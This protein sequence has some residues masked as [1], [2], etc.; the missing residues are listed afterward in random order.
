MQEIVKLMVDLRKT[1]LTQQLHPLIPGPL[2]DEDLAPI[3]MPQNR[4]IEHWQLPH[5]HIGKSF[6]L[7]ALLR[8]L[9][10]R[11]RVPLRAGTWVAG[12]RVRVLFRSGVRLVAH[13]VRVLLRS[14]VRVPARRV[15]APL[16]GGARLVPVIHPRCHFGSGATVFHATDRGAAE[17][18][19][20]RA[21]SQPRQEQGLG[22]ARVPPVHGEERGHQ[23]APGVARRRPDTPVEEEVGETRGVRAALR[24]V[25]HAGPLAVQA[26]AVH[27]AQVRR[28]PVAEHRRDAAVQHLGELGQAIAPPEAVLV[29]APHQLTGMTL[30]GER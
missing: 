15:R 28:A 4:G 2:G 29:D 19:D 8:R 26:Q 22:A 17:L 7:G 11:I 3:R 25:L 27:P 5:R 24:H 12:R 9:G 23:W 16:C 10:N 20:R 6:P 13:R 30:L 18:R 1:R 21:V 14:G